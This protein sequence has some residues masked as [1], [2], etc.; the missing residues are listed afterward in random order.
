MNLIVILD[1]EPLDILRDP[2]FLR[3]GSAIRL[4]LYP[5]AQSC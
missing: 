2:L 5:V 3:G 4:G 1:I